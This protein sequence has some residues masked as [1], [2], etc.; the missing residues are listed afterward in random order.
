MPA[1]VNRAFD[2]GGPDVL[3]YA[4]MMQRY[5]EVAG[6]PRRRML[7]VPVLSPTLSSHWVGLITP[8]PGGLA[9][10]LVESLRNTVVC[11]EHDIA[12]LRARSVR[13]G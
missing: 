13:P 10:P 7:K 1:D 6:L 3:T 11:R 9:R 4:D 2:I 8:V 5:A 12:D